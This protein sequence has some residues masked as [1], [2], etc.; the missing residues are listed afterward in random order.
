VAGAEAT[1]DVASRADDDARNV[2][3]EIMEVAP[4]LAGLQRKK[5]ARARHRAAFFAAAGSSSG[6]AA[7][8]C[9]G[10]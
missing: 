9:E 2:H 8:L 5:A 4:K 10:C 1:D 6:S 7:M 3:H